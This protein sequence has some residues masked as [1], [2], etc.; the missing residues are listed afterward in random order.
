MNALD[1]TRLIAQL[2]RVS[3]MSTLD[4]TI[5]QALTQVADLDGI[6]LCPCGAATYYAAHWNEPYGTQ[7][8]GFTCSADHAQMVESQRTR[9]GLLTA[10]KFAKAAQS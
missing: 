7:L 3:A 10:A 1:L 4:D 8:I 9:R 5:R 6:L 2:D